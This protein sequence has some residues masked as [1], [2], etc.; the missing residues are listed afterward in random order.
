MCCAMCRLVCCAVYRLMCRAV[1]RLECCGTSIPVLY[2][3][4]C[5]LVCCATGRSAMFVVLCIHLYA[6]LRAGL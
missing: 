2:C 1:Y 6:M 3:A 5:R 4:M